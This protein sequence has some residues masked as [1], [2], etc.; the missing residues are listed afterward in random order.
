MKNKYLKRMDLRV[1]SAEGGYTLLEMVVGMAIITFISGM[2][3]TNMRSFTQSSDVLA[4]AQVMASDIR[5]AQ[6]HAS[7]IRRHRSEPNNQK[8]SGVWGIYVNSLAG[9]N[10]EYVLYADFNAQNYDYNGGIEEDKTVKLP[11]GV[12][13]NKITLSGSG[14]V[15]GANVLFEAPGPDAVLN[16]VGGGGVT[17]D[18][19]EIEIL[20]TVSNEIKIVFVNKFGLVDVEPAA[21]VGGGGGGG[22]IGGL[23]GDGI[24]DSY[25][26]ETCDMAETKSDFE[27][28]VGVYVT[29][30]EWVAIQAQCVACVMGCV[31]RDSDGYGFYDALISFN[32]PFPGNDCE[33]DPDGAD[34]VFFTPDDGVNIN[35]GM[36]DDCSTF[37]DVD[38]NCN[39][40]VD[41]GGTVTGVLSNIDFESG[42]IGGVPANWSRTTEKHVTIG[43]TNADAL[44][45]SKS[46]LI[47]QDGG[48][49]YPGFCN[50]NTC[51]D[52]STVAGINCNWVPG[53][54]N[55]CSFPNPDVH[56][57]IA[58][59]EYNEG[60]VLQWPNTNRVSYGKLTYNVSSLTFDVDKMYIVRFY[61]KGVSDFNNTSKAA[62]G[63]TLSWLNQTW[64]ISAYPW[65]DCETYNANNGAPCLLDNSL[66]CAHADSAANQVYSYDSEI[67][68]IINDNTYNDWT[69]YVDSFVYT[70]DNDG[71]GP[72]KDFT[73]LRDDTGDKRHEIGISVGRNSTGGG[74]DLYID[75]FQLFRCD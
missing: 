40:L 26:G 27:S 71:P 58:P 9:T 35:P 48:Y 49:S 46:I 22:T 52:L 11:D 36:L 42:A 61:Y 44:S 74:S 2:I 37:D 50:F 7:S 30:A 31:D 1:F 55:K 47:H 16:V 19:I 15:N 70:A 8:A 38:N 45:G 64:D 39:G 54:P 53:A 73:L 65:L 63:Y 72:G 3:I 4:T 28:R 67:L 59:S 23:C 10:N 34:D 68:N 6:A 20:D 17:E 56:D 25:A 60:Q 51:N 62:F 21:I 57:L 12:I 43:I 18:S 33:D 69:L 41:E 24:V 32:C 5:I 66:C 29:F 14:V 13:I 75:D